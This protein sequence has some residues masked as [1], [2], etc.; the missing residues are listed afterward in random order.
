LRVARVIHFDLTLVNASAWQWWTAVSPENY[1]DGLIYTDYFNPGDPETI[2]P[3]KTLWALGNFSRF[4]RPG[5]IRVSLGGENDELDGLLASAYKNESSE[6][7]IVVYV[8]MGFS[9]IE[10][11]LTVDGLEETDRIASFTPYVTSDE[12]EHD[13]LEYP[14]ISPEEHYTVP[15]RSV[16]TLVGRVAPIPEPASLALLATAALCLFGRL[17]RARRRA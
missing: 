1:K 4:I 6:D 10:V 17:G 7:V 13:L 3:S 8:N 9:P 5:A 14:A 16:V 11:D 15:A 2:Y 12:W